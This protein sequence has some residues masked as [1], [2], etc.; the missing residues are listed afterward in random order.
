MPDAL[1]ALAERL[2]GV[3]LGRRV[4]V[5]L[6]ESCTGGLIAAAITAVPGSSGYFLGGVVSYANHAKESLLGV[7][8]GTL[9]A[10]G[11]V[12]AQVAKAMAEGAMA[13]FGASLGASVTG[14]A[15]PDGG[16]AA[17]PVGL[18]YLGIAT[19]DGTEVR[20]LQFG[21]DRQAIRQGAAS[22]VLQWLIERAEGAPPAG[23][24]AAASAEASLA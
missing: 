23:S 13:R 14:V 15:G 21:G 24:G 18:V 4:T 12:S 16:T 9:R 1:V 3:C 10:H 5:A 20:R 8:G 11:A 6:A 7:P 17:K 2:Q 19:A 22:A